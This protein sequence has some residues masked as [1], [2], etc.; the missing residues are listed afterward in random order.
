MRYIKGW[1]V[2]SEVRRFSKNDYLVLE[3]EKLFYSAT[4]L[5][6]SHQNNSS[7]FYID[8]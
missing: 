2:T 7:F 3:N 6:S 5:Q 4:S 8:R 1:K